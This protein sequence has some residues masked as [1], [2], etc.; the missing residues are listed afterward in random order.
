MCMIS[1]V[2]TVFITAIGDAR[3]IMDAS[4][5]IG[6]SMRSIRPVIGV[7]I[8]EESREREEISEK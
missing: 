3:R 2:R 6:R 1:V 7:V 4:I 8:G 5:M